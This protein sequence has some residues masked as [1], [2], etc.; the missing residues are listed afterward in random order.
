M[1]IILLKRYISRSGNLY[2]PGVYRENELPKHICEDPAYTRPVA[3]TEVVERKAVEPQNIVDMRTDQ[4]KAQQEADTQVIEITPMVTTITNLS[5]E[6]FAINI[7]TKAE[8][9]NQKGIGSKTAEK[10][11]EARELS[12]F[13][14]LYD[15]KERIDLPGLFEWEG[16]NVSFEPA[17]SSAESPNK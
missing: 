1:S 9:I 4:V 7:C 10:I 11:I 14:N 5:N 16:Y 3:S 6:P 15:L 2:N 13:I 17:P 8:L 12:P